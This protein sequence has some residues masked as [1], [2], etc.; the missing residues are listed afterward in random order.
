MKFFESLLV[1]RRSSRK[2]RGKNFT[3]E[4]RE[5]KRKRHH[6]WK[7]LNE[8]K[9]RREGKTLLQAVLMRAGTVAAE[10]RG[11]PICSGKLGRTGGNV[12]QGNGADKKSNG[13]IAAKKKGV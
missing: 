5:T 10:G 1:T 2:G 9:S 11:G 13:A 8:I 4:R 12:Y 7:Y 3:A 6:A